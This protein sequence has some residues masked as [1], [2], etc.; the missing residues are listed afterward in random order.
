MTVNYLDTINQYNTIKQASQTKGQMLAESFQRCKIHLKKSKA[1]LEKRDLIARTA[2]IFAIGKE[3]DQVNHIAI[4]SEHPDAASIVSKI[5]QNLIDA[6][7]N[8]ISRAAPPED[9][10]ELIELFGN[11]EA[12]FLS[13]NNSAEDHKEELR[14]DVNDKVMETESIFTAKKFEIV[15]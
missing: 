8:L 10:D 12:F 14:R 9:Y 2:E 3:L 13:A 1:A 6:V 5:K 7:Y 11:V 4:F 15:T